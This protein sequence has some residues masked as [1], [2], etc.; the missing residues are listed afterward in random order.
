MNEYTDSG[1]LPAEGAV[2]EVDELTL[3]GSVRE[4]L[5]TLSNE[6]AELLEVLRDA[7][8]AMPVYDRL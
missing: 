7:A 3:I 1:T 2:C 6:D 5:R 8:A 4:N